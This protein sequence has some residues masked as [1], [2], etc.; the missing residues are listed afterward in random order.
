MKPFIFNEQEYKD[1][2]SLGLAFVEHY[3]LA[4]Q[5]IKEKPWLKFLKILKSIKKEFAISF[6]KVD[7][8]RML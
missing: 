1:L 6:I 3:D 5:C 7:I 2:N 8:Y 4:L